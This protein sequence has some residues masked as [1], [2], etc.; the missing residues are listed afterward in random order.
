[1]ANIDI[2]KIEKLLYTNPWIKTVD[3]YTGING[4]MRIEVQQREALVR[5]INE[6]GESY[7]ID[8]DGK[9]MLWSGQ[10]TPVVP[11][12][13]GNIHEKYN[14]WY[15]TTVDEILKTDTLYAVTLLDDIFAMAKFISSNKMWTAQVAQV[16]VNENKEFEII[17]VVGNHRILFGDATDMEEKFAKLEVFYREGLNKTDWNAYDTVNVKYKNQVVCSKIN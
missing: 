3:A 13:T 8:R 17:P 1:M 2:N 5:I 12:F 14:I 4:T 6:G 16:Y 9:P 10:C 11:I 7:Y 15:R